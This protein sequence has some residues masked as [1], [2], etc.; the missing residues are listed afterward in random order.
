MLIRINRN[1][2]VYPQSTR[3]VLISDAQSEERRRV[4][5][6]CPGTNGEALEVDRDC[7]HA[8]FEALHVNAA[9][10]AKA[11]EENA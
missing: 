9:E 10:L 2:W 6:T 7:Q 3:I 4:W 5:V 8:V 11:A 1:T